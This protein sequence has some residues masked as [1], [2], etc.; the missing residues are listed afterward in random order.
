[1]EIED[2][3]NLL[4]LL[5]HVQLDT[6]SGYVSWAIGVARC[7]VVVHKLFERLEGGRVRLVVRDTRQLFVTPKARALICQNRIRLIPIALQRLRVVIIPRV[8]DGANVAPV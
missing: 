7:V 8:A 4:P 6:G 5:L 1:M 2:V 3:D